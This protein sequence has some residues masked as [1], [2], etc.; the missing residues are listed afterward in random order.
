L[1]EPQPIINSIIDTTYA[2][3]NLLSS[4]METFPD[5]TV[6]E[7]LSRSALLGIIAETEVQLHMYGTF[8]TEPNPAIPGRTMKVFDT[9]TPLN[10]ITRAI[11]D[12]LDRKI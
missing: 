2:V 1:Q 12:I 9:H 6:Q 11:F 5:L 4:I 10:K 3:K 7:A 8:T